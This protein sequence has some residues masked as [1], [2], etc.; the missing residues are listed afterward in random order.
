MSHVLHLAALAFVL[1]LG[2]DCWTTARALRRGLREAN[3]IMAAT[4]HP[5]FAAAALSVAFLGFATWASSAALPPAARN[6]TWILAALAV[7][8]GVAAVRNFRTIKESK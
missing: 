3:P 6:A 7:L 1:A 8:H 4:G 5:V 2:A